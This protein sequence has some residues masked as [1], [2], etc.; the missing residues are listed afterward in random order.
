MT[1]PPYKSVEAT[2]LSPA[3]ATF[4][5]AKADAAWPELTASA[6]TPPSSAATLFSRT[7]T[8]GFPILV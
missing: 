2:I 1:V 5:I 4:W 7:S 8:V 3:L 6:A